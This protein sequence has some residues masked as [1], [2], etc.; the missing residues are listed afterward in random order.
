MARERLDGQLLINIKA[1]LPDL[2]KLLADCTEHWAS[3]DLIYR[4]YHQSFKVYRLQDYTNRIVMALTALL[5]EPLR[6]T[7][8]GQPLN[9]WFMEI[10]AEGTGKKFKWEHNERWLEET[11]PI[12]EAFFHARYFLEM[13]IKYGKELD[14]APQM[15]PSGWAGLLCLYN[16]R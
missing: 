1:K 11:R 9:E 2:E 12:L 6:E 16:M 13:G 7:R 14:E 4:F 15:L 3:E 8:T 10:I 5:P